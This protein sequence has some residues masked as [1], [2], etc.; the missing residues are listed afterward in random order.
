[1]LK[2]NRNLN[3][4]LISL[5]I[6]MITAVSSSGQQRGLATMKENE[7]RRHLEFLAADEF[8]GRQT[9]SPE[10]EIATLYLA[11]TAK[12]MGLK[13]LLSDGSYYQTIPITVTSPL[14][15]NTRLCVIN[16]RGELTYYYSRSFGGRF[17]ASGTYSGEAVF[18]GLG[19][20]D[21]EK[22]WD[23]FHNLNLTG[24]VVIILDEQL[25]DVKLVHDL[26]YVSRLN[27]RIDLIRARGAAAVL[28]VVNTELEEKLTR[29]VNIFEWIPRGKAATSYESQKLNP[30]VSTSTQ[31]TVSRKQQRP[32]LPF[33]YAQISHDV[34]CSI[35]NVSKGDLLEMF[36]MA[37]RG[38]QVPGREIKRTRVQI[39]VEVETKPSSARNVIAHIE[40][41]DAIL[42]NEYV[43]VCAHHDHEGIS[44]GEVMAGAD[45]NGTGT[46]ALIEIAK[47]FMA[48]RPK[49]SVIIVWFTGE[50]IGTPFCC[51][52]SQYFINNCPVPVEKIS[53]CLNLDMF[54]SNN[55]DSLFITGSDLLS[56]ELDASIHKVNDKYNINFGFNYKFSNLTPPK[57]SL[58]Q[59]LYFRNDQYPF[60]RFGIPSTWFFGGFTLNYHTPRDLPEHID[61]RKVLKVAKLVYLTAFDIGNMN[62]LLKLDKNPEVIS[63]GSHNLSIKSLYH[64]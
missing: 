5:V 41:S 33:V 54:G 19:L 17:N 27:S 20:S 63:R 59:G 44:E 55:P 16:E 13:P 6:T 51:L 49:R 57:G 2:K 37:R 45:D 25:P 48:E 58:P 39:I 4:V 34:A 56:S 8:R 30:P 29:G 35:L 22:G 15:A 23:D 42:K 26:T 21:P 60:S 11:N 40:G 31:A 43:V 53:A 28:T 24:K 64:K 12:F 1:M 36:K 47:A 61:Y 32:F 18:A 14:R 50:E 38:L 7:L 10:L 3:S 52:G 46:V 9:P 62:N